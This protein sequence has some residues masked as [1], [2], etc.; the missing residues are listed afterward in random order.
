M[1]SLKFVIPGVPVSK[2]RPR[3]TRRGFTYTPRKTKNH[4]KFI[5]ETFRLFYPN[6]TPSEKKLTVFLE[7]I[8]KPPKNTSKKRLL[9]ML[10]KPCDNNKDLDNLSK[11]ILDSLNTIAYI[12][13]RQIVFLTAYK[14][15]G[16]ENKTR[17]EIKEIEE[18]T[19]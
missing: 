7:F 19:D 18:D 17:V 6:W 4:E 1:S 11:T 9:A 14:T 12:D 10:G 16:E 8:F 3:V 5:Q 13:D 15:W 2:E